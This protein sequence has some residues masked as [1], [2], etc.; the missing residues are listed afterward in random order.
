MSA[1]V[2]Y[3]M[4]LLPARLMEPRLC[5]NRVG[6]FSVTQE[7]YGTDQHRVARNCYITRWR[8]EPK[9]PSAAVSD[10]VKP[11]IFYIDPATPVKWV[12]WLKK[13]TEPWQ[14]LSRPPPLPH[15][16]PPPRAP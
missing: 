6:Y 2:H 5:D 4:V 14:P 9:D 7:D 10:A 1:L 8:L 11:I 15:P 12:P 16:L 3:S 13:G